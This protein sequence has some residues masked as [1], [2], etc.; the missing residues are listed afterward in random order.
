MGKR[1]KYKRKIWQ[2]ERERCRQSKEG[3]LEKMEG[4]QKQKRRKKTQWKWGKVERNLGRREK[5]IIN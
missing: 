1:D 4:K 5:E 2:D 3:E